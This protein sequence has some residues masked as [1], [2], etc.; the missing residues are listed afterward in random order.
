MAFW[1]SESH[2]FMINKTVLK[3]DTANSFNQERLLYEIDK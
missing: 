1:S 2:F 3:D